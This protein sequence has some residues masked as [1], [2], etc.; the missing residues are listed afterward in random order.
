MDSKD[1]VREV[2]DE[3]NTLTAEYQVHWKP[4]LYLRFL[5]NKVEI[6]FWTQEKVDTVIWKTLFM[7]F[8]EK[9]FI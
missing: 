7:V 3:R 8:K 4:K 9:G 1:Q 6:K 2:L 5:E